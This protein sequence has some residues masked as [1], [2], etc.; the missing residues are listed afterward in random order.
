MSRPLVSVFDPS[1]SDAGIAQ[2]TLPAVMTAPIRPDIVNYVHN[3]MSKNKRQAYAVNRMAGM[4]VRK[5][6][7]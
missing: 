4:E 3:L 1:N 2:A 5:R 6:I 7:E